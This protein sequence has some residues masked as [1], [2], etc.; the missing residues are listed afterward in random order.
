ML[1]QFRIE[2][3]RRPSQKQISMLDKLFF[4]IANFGWLFIRT[5][6]EIVWGRSELILIPDLPYPYTISVGNLAIPRRYNG[7][8]KLIG[9]IVESQPLRNGQPRALRRKESK[10]RE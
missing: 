8:V 10:L 3:V 1:N 4:V 7:K 5:A 2:I 6:I 9:P